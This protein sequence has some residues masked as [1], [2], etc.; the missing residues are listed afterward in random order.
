MS[1]RIAQWLDKSTSSGILDF[2]HVMIP[3]A[4]KGNYM[5]IA[6]TDKGEQISHSFE[7]KEYGLVQFY[8]KNYHFL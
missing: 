7:I 3:E 4:I 5:I 1:N 2:S 6:S 8:L